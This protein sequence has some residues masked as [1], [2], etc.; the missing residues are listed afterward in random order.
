M[1]AGQPS[2]APADADAVLA[3]KLGADEAASIAALPG[4]TGHDLVLTNCIVCHS[5]AMILQQR[6]DSA[7]WERTMTQMVT[8]GAPVSAEQRPVL[9][10][11][12][13]KHFGP[14][15]AKP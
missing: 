5:A 9:V 11:Y 8:W 12:L 13:N 15:A 6:K 14:G 1:S 2:G 4:G 7:G 10:A 3:A